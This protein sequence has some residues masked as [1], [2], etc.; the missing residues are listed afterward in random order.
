MINKN[1]KKEH[2]GKIPWK[3]QASTEL[4]R[5]AVSDHVN[6]SLYRY[7]ME[8]VHTVWDSEY[9][10]TVTFQLAESGTAYI[11]PNFNSPNFNSVMDMVR[12]RG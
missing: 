5:K 2:A 1:N 9:N 3:T 12:V 11:S 7:S 4:T 8:N 10:K 6:K